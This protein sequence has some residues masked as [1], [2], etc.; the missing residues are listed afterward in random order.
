M[1]APVNPKAVDSTNTE[2]LV[3]QTAH[4]FTVGQALYNG[5]SGWA[6][7]RNNAT[8]TLGTDLVAQVIDTNTFRRAK[9]GEV[10]GGYTGLTRGAVMHTSAAVAGAL[11]AAT[12]QD[13]A[14][15][16]AVA[17]NPLGEAVS[18]TEVLYRSSPAEII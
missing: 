15:A 5:P 3:T 2:F 4:G 8:A 10:I 7:A 17:R 12:T 14:P 13:G 18:T 16:S 11:A 1:S 6:L 9:E